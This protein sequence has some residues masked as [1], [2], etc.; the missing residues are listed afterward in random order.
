MEVCTFQH[1]CAFAYI[2]LVVSECRRLGKDSG[3]FY[4]ISKPEYCLMGRLIQNN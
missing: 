3:I 1:E 2:V 4:A